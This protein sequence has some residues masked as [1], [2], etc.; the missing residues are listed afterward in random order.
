VGVSKK[1]PDG[2][3]EK[4]RCCLLSP[5]KLLSQF[6]THKYQPGNDSGLFRNPCGYFSF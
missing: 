5:Q 3:G 2:T 6:F 4:N 1:Q